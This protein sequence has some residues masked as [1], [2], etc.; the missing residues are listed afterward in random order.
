MDKLVYSRFA[1][2]KV[3]EDDL[4]QSETFPFPFVEGSQFR[5]VMC[6][7]DE[8]SCQ[9]NFEDWLPGPDITWSMFH[10]EVQYVIR[11]RAE[12]EIWHPPLMQDHVK[13]VAEPGC[14][15]LLPRG[16]RV[17]WRVLGDEPFRHLCICYPNPGYPVSTARSVAGG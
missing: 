11:G 13:V 14:I 9:V 17:L 16:A 2:Y 3:D 12:I 5:A 7:I 6:G 10:D 8:P 15:Y 1:M 4:E